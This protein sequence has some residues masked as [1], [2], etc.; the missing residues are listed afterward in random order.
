MLPFVE[1]KV[2][3]RPMELADLAPVQEIDRMSFTIPWP[4]SAFRYE[5]EENPLSDVWVAEIN[6]SGGG[7]RVVGELVMWE[8]LDEAHIATIAVHPDYRNRGIAARMLAVAL[9]TAIQKGLVQATLEV[10]AQNLPAQRLYKRFGFEVLGIRPKYYRD[11]NEDALIMT[12]SNLDEEY[13]NW[14][15]SGLWQSGSQSQPG[16]MQV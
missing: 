9:K 13:F 6:H 14:L 8:V 3:I 10:R 12:V 4:A 2:V 15:Q 11:N 16:T 1:N 7:L 5:L